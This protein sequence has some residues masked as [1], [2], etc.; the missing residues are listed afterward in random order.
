MDPKGTLHVACNEEISVLA[1]KCFVVAHDG[2]FEFERVK[3]YDIF[4]ML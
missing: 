1:D 4:N 2:K 3:Y